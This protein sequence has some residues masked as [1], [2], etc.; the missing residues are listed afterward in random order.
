MHTARIRTR[1]V[2]LSGAL[3]LMAG[4]AIAGVQPAGAVTPPDQGWTTVEAPLPND[5]G[6]SPDVY[7]ASSTCPAQN[8]CVSVGDYEDAGTHWWGV[9]ETQSGTSWSDT[10]APEPANAGSGSVQYAKFGSSQCGFFLVSCTA[11]SC[12]TTTFCVAVG[13]YEDTAGFTYP[14]IDTFANGKW[15]ATTPSRCWRPRPRRRVPTSSRRWTR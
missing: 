2:S 13:G 5:A 1:V 9:I 6:P 14:L 11:V 7:V 8:A 15:T 4:I 10:E 12:P 3:V